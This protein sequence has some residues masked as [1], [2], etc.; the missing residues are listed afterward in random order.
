MICLNCGVETA[1]PKFC[2][3]SCAAQYNNKQFPKR[4]RK[5][6]RCEKCGGVAEY[7]RKFC[8]DCSPKNGVDWSKRTFGFVRSSLDFHARI[9]QLARKAY[10]T[11][12][13]PSQCVVCGYSKHIEIC[14]IK[15]IQEFSEH[16][17]ISVIN[18]LDNL[19]ALCPNCHWEFDHGL[20]KSEQL[21]LR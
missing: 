19:V 2:S 14:H 3:R 20:L 7:R 5:Q 21:K 13:R 11:S 9:R 18:S 16:T 15:S 6:F 10:Y 1:N 4:D 8:E 17:P 12:D